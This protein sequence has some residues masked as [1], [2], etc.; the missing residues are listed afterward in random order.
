M[1]KLSAECERRRETDARLTELKQQ[2][3]QLQR[4]AAELRESERPRQQQLAADEDALRADE[5]RLDAAVRNSDA[6]ASECH[7]DQTRLAEYCTRLAQGS[8]SSRKQVRASEWPLSGLSLTS[9]CLFV[10]WL[11]DWV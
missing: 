2:M 7:R 11:A 10:R 6:K 8:S 3:S 1:T 5:L 9:E 4:E